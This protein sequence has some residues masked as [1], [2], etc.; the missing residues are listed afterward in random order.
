HVLGMPGLARA[1]LAVNVAAYAVLWALLL[2]RLAWFFPRVAADL[3]DHARGP[4]FFT[5]VAATCLLGSQ[6]LLVAEAVGAARALWYAGL[7]L[8]AV[9]MYAFFTA[10][11]VRE[12]KPSLE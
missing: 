9:I 7:A 11:V 4:G 5:L 12:R 8:W 2:A 6:L 3:T 10:V 1:L